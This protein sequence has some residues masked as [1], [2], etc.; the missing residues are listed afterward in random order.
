MMTFQFG[1]KRKRRNNMK[2]EYLTNHSYLC[3]AVRDAARE[4]LAKT[5]TIKEV[6][7]KYELP[8]EWIESKVLDSTFEPP[9]KRQHR[10]HSVIE[11]LR[12]TPLIARD[13]LTAAEK[14]L[15][16]GFIDPQQKRRLHAMHVVCV[17]EAATAVQNKQLTIRAACEMHD[18][19][20]DDVEK[21]LKDPSYEP[22]KPLPPNFRVDP[23]ST[24]KKS[25]HRRGGS[26]EQLR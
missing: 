6:A 4:V 11:T 5:T 9:Q 25:D 10:N 12:E 19:T 14:T 23:R 13:V 16:A 2:A 3:T 18:V 8:A 26:M 15:K 22:P 17:A 20:V 24:N 7:Q 1:N 21:R